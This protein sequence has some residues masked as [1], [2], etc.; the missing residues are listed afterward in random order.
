MMKDILY[1]VSTKQS[2]PVITYISYKQSFPH[3]PYFLLFLEVNMTK[4]YILNSKEQVFFHKGLINI[5]LL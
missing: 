5:L 1:I 4:I 3:Q 2:V